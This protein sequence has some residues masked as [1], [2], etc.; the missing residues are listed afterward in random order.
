MARLA[1]HGSNNISQCTALYGLWLLILHR[2]G[3]SCM[4]LT[5][6]DKREFIGKW[7][8]RVRYN[9]FGAQLVFSQPDFWEIAA[10]LGLPWRSPCEPPFTAGCPGAARVRTAGS[11]RMP[12]RS[13][14]ELPFMGGGSGAVCANCHSPPILLNPKKTVIV[15]GSSIAN[16]RNMVFAADGVFDLRKIVCAVDV[17]FNLK[18]KVFAADV[19]VRALFL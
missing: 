2:Y 13:L 14:C 8:R 3:P 19:F 11:G 5:R 6:Q 12:W 4:A 15:A 7:Q 1:K 18:R 10:Y 17:C 9:T 16:R